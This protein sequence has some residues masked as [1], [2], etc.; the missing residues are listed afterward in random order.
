MLK[1]FSFVTEVQAFVTE[2]LT[3]TIMNSDTIAHAIDGHY[4]TNIVFFYMFRNMIH[5]NTPNI[6]IS[7]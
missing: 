2:N 1:Q 4:C 5:S 3:A 7:D 6:S